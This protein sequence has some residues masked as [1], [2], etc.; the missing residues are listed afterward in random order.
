[1]T[2]GKGTSKLKRVH[3]KKILALL[4]VTAKK[5]EKIK[6]RGTRTPNNQKK[7]MQ[8]EKMGGWDNKSRCGG[9]GLKKFIK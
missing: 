9:R 7:K 4:Q 3:I 5:K 1:M 2:E 8:S 6:T